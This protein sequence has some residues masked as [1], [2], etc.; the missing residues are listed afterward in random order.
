[1]LR[2]AEIAKDDGSFIEQQALHLWNEVTRQED[3]S[4]RLDKRKVGDLPIA[5]QRQLLRLAVTK[6]LGDIRDIEAVHIEALRNLLGKSVGK[7]ISLP[8]G[9]VCWSEYNEVVIA[10]VTSS[11]L[12]GEDEAAPKKQ[13]QVLPF[14]PCPF[15]PFPVILSGAK[16]LIPL[17]IPGETILPGWKVTASIVYEQMTPLSSQAQ[18]N[19]GEGLVPSLVAEFDLHQTGTELF[20]RHRQSGDR[21]QPLGMDMPKKIQRFMVDAKIPLRWREHIPIVCSP[22]QII[23]VVGWRIDD[24]VKVTEATREILRLEFIRSS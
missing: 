22:Q 6:I 13:S 10:S 24:R 17:K 14:P 18:E 9:I 7:R 4:I 20:V 5:L 16:N 21:F 23:W 19:V 8:H 11:P 3:N 15:P 12:K 1:M 2:L